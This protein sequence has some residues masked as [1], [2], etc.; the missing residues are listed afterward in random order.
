MKKWIMVGILLLGFCLVGCQKQ[1]KTICVNLNDVETISFPTLE[2]LYV[3]YNPG[4]GCYTY[5]LTVK[6]GWGTELRGYGE[7][8]E[9]A[10]SELNESFKEF[11]Q[12]LCEEN[13]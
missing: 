13:L 4:D 8:W 1:E 2:G 3:M 9:I 7:T 5:W 6:L 11:K 12:T 10:V